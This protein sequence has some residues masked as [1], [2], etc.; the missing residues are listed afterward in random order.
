MLLPLPSLLGQARAGGYGIGYFE[1][2]DTYSFEAV[3]EAAEAEQSPVILG[4]GC[5]MVDAPW[6]DD[7]G[8]S[9]LGAFGRFA[10]ER[11]GVPAAFL[12]NETHTYEEALYGI[13]AGFN[14]VM[15][16]TSGWLRSE[17]VEQVSRLVR[18]A[19]ARG[20]AVEAELGH[21]P[22]A[23]GG[24]FSESTGELTDPAGAAAFVAQTGVDCLAVA[25][26]NV[27]LLLGGAAPVDLARLSAIH[28]RV[29]VPLVLHGGTGLP[30]AAVP[31]AICRGVAKFNVGTIL[32]RAFLDGV[33]T[34][35]G[36]A[37]AGE[38]VHA[39]LGSHREADLMVAGK[40]RMRAVV[41][42][43]MQLYGSSGRARTGER[44]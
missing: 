27:H 2:W 30:A 31:E 13:E 12:L 37:H 41:R 33:R 15:P 20:V 17:V 23:I 43:F 39:M 35:V 34:A 42:E 24:V 3:V 44:S 19:H 25:I 11:A 7:G 28:E 29:A 36:S 8:I 18:V 5:M 22:T 4:F 21:L 26:G 9:A 6:L 10:A 32:K 1:A 14:A 40:Q 16:D 38:D